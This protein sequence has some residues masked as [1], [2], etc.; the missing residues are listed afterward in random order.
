MIYLLYLDIVRDT[1]YMNYRPLK[2][3][4]FFGVKIW[5]NCFFHSIKKYQLFN[6]KD[7]S[8]DFFSLLNKCLQNIPLLFADIPR[9]FLYFIAKGGPEPSLNLP[10][11][12]RYQRNNLL[13]ILIYA[14]LK[15]RP[16]LHLHV[17]GCP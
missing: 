16:L 9:V 14:E 17:R 11:I 1:S 3:M 15:T 5:E 4:N 2:K 7:Q 8:T 6:L 12:V 10:L 13:L